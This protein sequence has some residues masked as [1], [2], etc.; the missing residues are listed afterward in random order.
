MNPNDATIQKYFEDSKSWLEKGDVRQPKV[1]VQLELSKLN[2]SHSWDKIW[3]THSHKLG[4][5]SAVSFD[6][7]G[8]VVVFHRGDHVWDGASFS[9]NNIYLPRAKGPIVQ[10]TII[11]YDRGTGAIVDEWGSG[12]FCMIPFI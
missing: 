5:V 1:D 2:F 6:N 12:M 9:T 4:S 10:N 11:T 8:N 3:P 7:A